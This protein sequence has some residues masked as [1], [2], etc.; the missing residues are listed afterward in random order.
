MASLADSRVAIEAVDPEIDGGRFPAKAVVGDTVKVEA[1]IFCDGHDV[2]DAVVLYRAAGGRRWREAP[3]RFHDNDR[4]RGGFEIEK[5][6]PYEFTILA[7]RDLFAAWR[8]EVQKK[9]A[10]GQRVSSELTEGERLVAHACDGDRAG[11]ADRKLLDN[12]QN[13]LA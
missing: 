10:A 2:I 5:Q 9:V 7:W 4:W 12:L 13:A 6:T 11:A 8:E 3:M 1:D